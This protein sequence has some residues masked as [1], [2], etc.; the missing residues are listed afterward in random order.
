[1]PPWHV[2]SNFA[3]NS[4]EGVSGFEI[5]SLIFRGFRAVDEWGPGGI[6]CDFGVGRVRLGKCLGRGWGSVWGAPVSIWGADGSE[7][8][9]F[10]QAGL[11]SYVFAGGKKFGWKWMTG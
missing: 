11:K 1:M 5:R 2:L 7:V 4:P 10:P 9:F 6:T 8:L 3:R